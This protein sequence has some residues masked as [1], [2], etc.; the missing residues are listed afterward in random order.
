MKSGRRCAYCGGENA[1]TKDHVIS[2]SLYP[3]LEP[4]KAK[5]KVRRITVPAC[6]ACNK[7]WSADEA[8]F[9]NMLL[10]CGNPTPTVRKLWERKTR[11]SFLYPDGKKQARDLAAQ[12]VIT[13]S[14]SHMVYPARDERVMR[15]VRKV[16]RGLSYYHKVR[17][18]ISDDESWADVQRF[19]IQSDF[20]VAMQSFHVEKEIFQY[21][22]S[23][24]DDPNF[25]SC[26]VLRF[27]ERTPFLCIV[28]HSAEAR[29]RVEAAPI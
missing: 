20:F 25:N 24:M 12:I 14:G 15:L 27:F 13:Q 6:Q 29:S 5:P 11:R 23:V 3:P 22:F 17:W 21:R 16:V 18:P 19:D 10:L 28:F 1:F 4:S 2:R 9:R 8:H 26:W 7:S